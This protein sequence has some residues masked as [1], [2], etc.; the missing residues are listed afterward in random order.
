[1]IAL[2]TTR[3][4]ELKS[5]GISNLVELR[6]GGETR[7]VRKDSELFL[8]TVLLPSWIAFH[9]FHST[10]LSVKDDATRSYLSK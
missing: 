3:E 2:V 4:K 10:R 6:R 9:V 7:S 1:M 8:D 5:G